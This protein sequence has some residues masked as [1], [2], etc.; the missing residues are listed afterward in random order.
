MF[1]GLQRSEVGLAKLK[2]VHVETGK[3][4]KQ[5]LKWKKPQKT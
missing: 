4:D 1:E 3:E 5:K 2:V